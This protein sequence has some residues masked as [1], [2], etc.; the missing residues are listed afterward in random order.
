MIKNRSKYATNM[1]RPLDM[2]N[3]CRITEKSTTNQPNMDLNA[4]KI[5][6]KTIQYRWK[7]LEKSTRI[8]SNINPKSTKNQSWGPLGSSSGQKRTQIAFGLGIL[9]HFEG[10]SGRLGL[11]WA[12][13][14][15]QHGSKLAAQ[16]GPKSTKIQSKN[17]LIF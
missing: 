12:E 13:K 10:L 5:N 11:S 15:S 1:E 16:T 14:G 6:Q 8:R 9:W 3:R 7:I 4:S 2:K 17:Q